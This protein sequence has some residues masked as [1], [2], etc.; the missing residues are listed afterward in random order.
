MI[1]AE[2]QA[3]ILRLYHAEKWKLGTIASQLRVHHS[4][5]RRVL[6]QAGI[7]V[8][9]QAVRPSMI[10]PFVPFVVETLTK[11][12]TLRA[13]RLYEMVRQR[14][15]PG[16]PDHFRAMVARYRPRRPAEAYLRLR[17]LAGEQAQVDWAHFGKLTIGR[18]VRP[19]MGFVMVLSWSRQVFLRFYPSAAQA[20]FLRG[21]VEAFSFYSSVP[22]VILYDNLKSAV[23][24]RIGDAIRFH[25]VLLE[26][27]AHYRFAPRPV[28]VARGNEKG[29]VERAIRYVRDNFFAARSWTDLDDLNAQALAWCGGIAADRRWPQDASRTVREAFAAERKHLLEL[30]E[31]AFPTDE[32]LEVQ[33]GKTPYVR[34]DL[35]DYSVPHTSVRRTLTVLAS[36]HS[37][38]VLEGCQLVATH[39]RS[40]DRD[41][42]IEDPAHIQALVAAKGAGAQHRGMDRLHHAAPSCQRLF[43]EIAARGGNLGSVTWGLIRLLDAHGPGALEA[44]IAEA[45]Q[46]GVPHLPAVRQILDSKRH[47]QGRP[48]A[49]PVALPDDPRVRDLVVRDH[50]LADYEA[51]HMDGSG[52]SDAPDPP[53]E[54]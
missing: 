26:L 19:L 20:N 24:E 28:A 10:D 18:A 47:Q 15:Y 38:R 29:R 49:I 27:A 52:D 40:W 9:R 7:P 13:S 36:L 12:P 30:P 48:P 53:T 8:S 1:P 46:R 34:F 41:Q 21:H 44:A 37:V 6:A 33:V 17:T 3:E 54:S 39:A 5:V 51:L 4:T 42:Q 14:G 11:Y 23:L 31:R 50:P 43:A 16:Q 45:L 25:P 22:R 32:R 35:N 2:T